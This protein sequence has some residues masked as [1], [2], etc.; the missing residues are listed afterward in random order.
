M[1]TIKA[2][3]NFLNVEVRLGNLGSPEANP[4]VRSGPMAEDEEFSA[5][6]V[7]MFFRREGTPMQANSGWTFWNSV[8]LGQSAEVV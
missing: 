6:G 5:E 1:L 3:R 7:L 8:S 2:T 4:L